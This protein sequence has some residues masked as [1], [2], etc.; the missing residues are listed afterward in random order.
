MSYRD[1]RLTVTVECM[2][3]GFS[4][5]W[6][7]EERRFILLADD[8]EDMFNDFLLVAST[9]SKRKISVL[10]SAPSAPSDEPDTAIALGWAAPTCHIDRGQPIQPDDHTAYEIDK[11][12]RHALTCLS[13]VTSIIPLI[14]FFRLCVFGS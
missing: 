11:M 2:L 10:S 1:S 6:T 4:M 9:R 14:S 5:G 7:A 12:V 3:D 8:K 13:S